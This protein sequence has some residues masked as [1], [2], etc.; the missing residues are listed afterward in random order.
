MGVGGVGFLLSLSIP[1][2]SI[3]ASAIPSAGLSAVAGGVDVLLGE[4]SAGVVVP[5]VTVNCHS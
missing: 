1:T 3:D 5:T 2:I 4:S